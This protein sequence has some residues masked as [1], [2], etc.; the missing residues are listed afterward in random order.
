MLKPAQ[1]D[2][3]LLVIEALCAGSVRLDGM[4]LADGLL[5]RPIELLAAVAAS[6]AVPAHSTR[7]AAR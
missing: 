3:A 6:A 1:R 5:V 2:R 4:M 7:Q